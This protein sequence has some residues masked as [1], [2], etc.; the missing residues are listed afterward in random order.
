MKFHICLFSFSTLEWANPVSP[1]LPWSAIWPLQSAH[2]VCRCAYLHGNAMKPTTSF[3]ICKR[4]SA[5]VSILMNHMYGISRW[6]YDFCPS[7]HNVRAGICFHKNWSIGH[8]F[9]QNIDKLCNGQH[10][11][12][13]G[14]A[15]HKMDNCEHSAH[16]HIGH[17]SGPKPRHVSLGLL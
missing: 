14:P 12:K 7:D 10:A 17:I 9:R 1:K 13:S 5:N 16:S 3:N 4:M 8:I 11:N 15:S 2:S 6:T